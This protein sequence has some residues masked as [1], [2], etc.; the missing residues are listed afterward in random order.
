M[1][2]ELDLRNK[3]TSEFR[4]VFHNPLGVPNSQVALIMHACMVMIPIQVR[5]SYLFY[6]VFYCHTFYII[7]S[8]FIQRE[9]LLHAVSV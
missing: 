2:I 8:H 7:K 9:G 6:M 5:V 3:T 4:K 1:Y